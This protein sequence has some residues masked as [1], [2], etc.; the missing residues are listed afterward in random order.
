M[1]VDY[2]CLSDYTLTSTCA[3][4][5]NFFI[6]VNDTGIDQDGILGL[7]PPYS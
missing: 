6:I 5:F 7:G 4:G 2:V 1:G 3:A